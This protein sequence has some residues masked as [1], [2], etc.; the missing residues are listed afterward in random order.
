MDA[1]S[2]SYHHRRVVW[3]G[4]PYPLGASWDG[5]GVNFALFSAH[6]EAVDL[7]IFD[8][9]G[10]QEIER[11]R[12]P[13][14]TDEVWHA[15][16][17]DARPGMLYGYRVYGP[18][19]PAN[20][21][22]FNPHKLL[23]DPYAKAIHGSV[24]WTDAHFG[25]RVGSP[26]EDLSFDRRDNARGMPKA[27][28]ID[29]AFT[30]GEDR[31]PRVPW[32]QSVIVELHV[33]G[34]T[35]RH[36]GVDPRRRGTFAGLASPP[37]I[38]YLVQLGVTAI[39]LLPVQAFL[40]DRHLT[41]R[42]LTNYWGYNTYGFFAPDP[43]FLASTSVHEFKTMVKRL[44]D[45]G[46][47]VILDVVY[48]HTAEGNHMG[49][50]LSFRGIDNASYY[51][52]ADD[53]RYYLDYTGTG[54]VL[55]TDHPRVLQLIMDS[56]RYWVSEMHVDGFRFD[57]APTLAR[58][59]GNFDRGSAF[60]DAIRQD[61][62]LSTVK[63]IAE[64]W[65]IGPDGY[66]LGAFP[67][68]WAEWNAGYRDTVR[69]FWKGD[70]GLIAELASRVAGSSDIFGRHGRRPWA[71]INFVTAH[72]GFPLVDLVSYNE[73]H[74]EANREDNRDGHDG[75][76]SW[77][78]G[79]EGPTDDPDVQ[80]LRDRQKRNFLATLLLSLGVPMLLAGDELGRTQRG[81][82]NAYCQDSELSWIDWQNIRPEDEQLNAFVRHLIA[83]RRQHRVFSR[84]RF[85]R[86]EVMAEDGLKDITWIAPDGREQTP[87]DWHN[88]SALCLGF[89]LGGA[90]GEYYTQGGQRDIDESFLVLMNAYHE[91]I[92]FQIPELAA[93][94]RWEVLID[95]ALPSG[96]AERGTLFGPAEVYALKYRSFVLFINRTAAPTA[97][98][99]S[100]VPGM[101]VSSEE[102]AGMLPIA[103]TA[104]PEAVMAE[105]ASVD[106]A[107]PEM[108]EPPEADETSGGEAATRELEEGADL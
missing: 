15:Y 2:A 51:R 30:W 33:R 16:L 17:P 107:L 37:V 99:E 29:T 45:A 34:M 91:D 26:R 9:T 28:V 84:P 6:A 83:L 20:G 46:I 10:S 21:H 75:N 23:L 1:V 105:R 38:D 80:A 8:D 108:D 69:R 100:A 66:Q 77:N 61:P 62:L 39:E 55:N 59:H 97:S 52:L 11:V 94:S 102:P 7:C 63:L 18:Y 54:N 88:P 65:D 42:K 44:H 96:I 76:F 92:E 104:R 12:L 19:D 106:V 86:G 25:Y 3:P 48:N 67:P 95:T 40:N 35:M 89:V 43:R 22:R 32:E 50:T 90:A 24:R 14:Y 56:L 78:C 58:E 36:P 57:L 4:S 41:Q 85:F 82:N 60:F 5:R 47:E 71:S 70:P 27:M 79:V 81:N 101:L 68:G 49:P 74:N 93:S 31:R 98:S 103:A 72:D 73:K 13:D 53:R 64:P 87:A